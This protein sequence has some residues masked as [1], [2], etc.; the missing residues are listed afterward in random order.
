LIGDRRLPGASS[1]VRT[2]WSE[3]NRTLE[4]KAA[5]TYTPLA[6]ID[7]SGRMLA[8]VTVGAPPK[9]LVRVVESLGSDSSIK[10][11]ALAR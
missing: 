7:A 9:Q 5:L 6:A 3:E 1:P 4:V 8:I 10:R 2:A 11:T